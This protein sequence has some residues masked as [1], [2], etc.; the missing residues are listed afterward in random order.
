MDTP[1]GNMPLLHLSDYVQGN[2][3]L[4]SAISEYSLN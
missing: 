3:P 4:D 1:L 2:V